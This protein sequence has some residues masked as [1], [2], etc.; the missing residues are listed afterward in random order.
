MKLRQKEE[1]FKV[2]RRIHV[3]HYR[4][5]IKAWLQEIKLARGCVDCGY[6]AHPAA[7]DFDHVGPKT[8]ALAWA[9]ATAGRERMIAELEQCEVRCANC[10]RIKTWE[11][12]VN[13]KA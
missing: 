9:A 8:F 5:K 11:E 1:D 10:H 13:A 12:R 2:S 7:L 4:A 3:N 6:R